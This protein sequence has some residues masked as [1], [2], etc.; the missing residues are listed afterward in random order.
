MSSKQLD[1]KL[2][3]IILSVIGDIKVRQATGDQF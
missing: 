1:L 3:G 2:K